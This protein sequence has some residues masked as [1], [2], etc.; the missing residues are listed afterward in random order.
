MSDV[1]DGFCSTLKLKNGQL[2]DLGCGAVEPVARYFMDQNWSVIGVNFSEQMIGLASKY[3]PEMQ[4]IHAD[5]CEVD[6]E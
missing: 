2:L 5:T 6:F 4:T 3:V 1:L